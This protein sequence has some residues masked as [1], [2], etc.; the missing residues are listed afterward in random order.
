MEVSKLEMIIRLLHL[1][2]W[3]LCLHRIVG[4]LCNRIAGKSFSFPFPFPYFFPVEF[5]IMK[6]R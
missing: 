4:F 3:G 1:A 5:P 2:S 6:L